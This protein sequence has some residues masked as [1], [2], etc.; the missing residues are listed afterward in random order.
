MAM[1]NINILIKTTFFILF[2]CVFLKTEGQHAQI[3]IASYYASKFHGKPTASGEK[4]NMN[5]FTAAHPSLP[6]QTFVKVT[7]LKNKKSVIVRINDRGPHVKSRVIDLSKAAAKKIGLIQS[8]TAKVKIE[9]VKNNNAENISETEPASKS[10]PINNIDLKEGYIYNEEYKVIH[11][12]GCYIQTASFSDLNNALE[13]VN[14][15]KRNFSYTFYIEV[16]KVK[17]KKVF[18]VLTGPFANKNIAESEL[19]K[20]KKAGFKG[21]VREI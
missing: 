1:K 7:N 18:R 8:G 20:I 12:K 16:S 15:L 10:H 19:K 4:Y 17:S 13:S 2:S 11:L 6:F 3:G 21:L 5:D 14:D 9:V